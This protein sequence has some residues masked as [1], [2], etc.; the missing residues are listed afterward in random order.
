M[1]TSIRLSRGGSKK[2][3]Y[4]KIV[5]ADS[6]SP[7]DGRFIERIG[8]Y[9]PLLGKDNPDRVKLDA[10]RAKHWVSVGAQP[11]DR[12]ARFLDSLELVKRAPRN[13]P[14]KAVPGKKAQERAKAKAA[15]SEAPAIQKTGMIG[16]ADIDPAHAQRRA[17]H[18]PLRR[19]QHHRSFGRTRGERHMFRLTVHQCGNLTARNFNMLASLA[20][21]IMDGRR[22]AE[23]AQ[24]FD[25]SHACRIQQRSTGIII[26]ICAPRFTVH[27]IQ[28]SFVQNPAGTVRFAI[29]L[30]L[31][32]EPSYLTALA[33]TARRRPILNNSKLALRRPAQRVKA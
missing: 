5:V 13:N 27:S 3:P 28:K 25:H 12:V 31:T 22:I 14:N 15:A 1:A 20:P 30:K 7:R 23:S 32:V 11:T 4:Y 18:L 2:R 9:N 19:Q 8:S 16:F 26:K 33:W 29:S 24:R 17:A 6:R 10:Q 21:F